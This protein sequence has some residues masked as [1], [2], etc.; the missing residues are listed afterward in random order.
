M[1]KISL[2][3]ILLLT[4]NIIFA[5][6]GYGN[7]SN[8]PKEGVLAGHV[9]DKQANK[10]VEYA[11]VALFSKRDSSVVSGTISDGKGYFKLNKLPYGRF[12]LIVNFIGYEKIVIEDI[13]ITL[14]QKTLNL[15]DIELK[16]ATQELE[17]VEVVANRSYI[18]YKI[19]KKVVNVSQHINAEGGSAADVLENTPS[20]E[21]DIEG[22]VSLRGNSN[23]TVL[24]DGK[25]TVL[26]A[27]DVLQQTPATAIANIEIITNPSAKYDPEGT[28]GIINLVMKKTNKVGTNGI[29]NL[30]GSTNGTNSSYGGNFLFN[31]RNKKINYFIGAN[32]RSS[33]RAMDGY[34][35]RIIY[36]EN[37]EEQNIRQDNYRDMEHGGGSVK[38]GID[39]YLGDNTTVSLS[40]NIGVFGFGRNA[41]TKYHEWTKPVSEDIYSLS[42]EGFDMNSDY[43]SGTFT[44]MHKFSQPEH[45]LTATAYYSRRFGDEI[46]ESKRILTDSYFADLG[47]TPEEHNRADEGSNNHRLR[48]NIDYTL[49]LANDMKLDFGY[50]GETMR[51]SADYLLE[52]FDNITSSWQE[53]TEFTNELSFNRDIHALYGQFSSKLLGFKYQ[54]GLRGEYTNRIIEQ[55]T[56]KNKYE[57]NRFDYFPSFHVSRDL[58]SEQQIQLSYSKRIRRPREWFLN[59]YP[60]HSDGYTRMVGNP[61]L[62]PEYTDSYELNY[63]KRINRSFISLELFYRHT[64]DEI[65]R[66]SSLADDGVMEM[67]FTNIGKE[68][69]LGAELMTNLQL[70]KWWILN[71][72]TSAYQ[73]SIEGNLEG[74]DINK[75]DITWRSRLNSTFMLS[76]TMRI[77]VNG[78]YRGASI[79]SQGSREAMW[80]S[81]FAIRKDFFKRK[82]NVTFN[83]R[84]VFGTM[85]RDMIDEGPS[86][87]QHI[88]MEMISPIYS[89]SISYKINNY[90][91]ERNRMNGGDGDMNME[92][93]DY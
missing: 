88:N 76:P 65:D 47:L 25:P 80:M 57:I 35:D 56:T 48:T 23:F 32:Y 67:T 93:M 86:Y 5:Q 72:S 9:I 51:N 3:I 40:G 54:L 30:R 73:L 53:N 71:F 90:K 34:V 19:D 91:Q 2:L 58:A 66:I 18:E 27:N 7:R 64:K 4:S 59:P 79:T 12:Y 82:L 69:S 63:Q 60:R 44:L 89:I 39:Y 41:N 11:N 87:W 31:I 70:T 74:T 36:L 17:E 84:D 22:N 26:D 83:V 29:V 92:E 13:K 24:I 61:A 8:M 81:N 50:Q 77:Q 78:M 15:G 42:D 55:K 21:V 6:H 14:K 28:A 16:Q 62:G 45:K 52:D 68:A 20:V 33:V 37:D 85:K 43:Y 38:A 1:N 10:S 49:P 46:S 75:N